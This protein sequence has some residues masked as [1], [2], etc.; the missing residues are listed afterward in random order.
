MHVEALTNQRHCVICLHTTS[1]T[2]VK[3]TQLGRHN[4]AL[5]QSQLHSLDGPQ[6]RAVHQHATASTTAY[7]PPSVV[8]KDFAGAAGA[9]LAGVSCFNTRK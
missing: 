9:P 4:R 8:P 2:L 6:P 1:I 3:H 7:K 5:D